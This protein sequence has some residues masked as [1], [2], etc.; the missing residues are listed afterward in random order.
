VT[1][2]PLVPGLGLVV[3]D[4]GVQPR[5]DPGHPSAIAPGKRPRLTP[6]PGSI[7]RDGQVIMAYG[8]P[9]G[10]VQ[11]Q[12]LVQYVVDL[13]D[14][15]MDPQ[16]AIEAPRVATCSFPDSFYPNSYQPDVVVAETLLPTE[17]VDE[18][19]HRG[20]DVQPW[21]DWTRAAGS[22]RA[23][24]VD[25]EHGTLMGAADPRRVAYALGW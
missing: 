25:R 12:A 13:I 15:A 11:P 16:A 17:V 22:L 9:G 4:R 8:T 20:H 5:L 23:A 14:F 6:S 3:S 21:P 10:D 18:L 2:T 7:M 19:R 24:V 1:T